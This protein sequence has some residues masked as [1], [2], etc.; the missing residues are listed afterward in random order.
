MFNFKKINKTLFV[1][2]SQLSTSINVSTFD[3]IQ[4]KKEK[5]TKTNETIFFLTKGKQYSFIHIHRKYIDRN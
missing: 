1:S 4:E 3:R 5:I 2:L